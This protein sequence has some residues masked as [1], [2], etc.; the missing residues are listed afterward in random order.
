MKKETMLN[1]Q[2]SL[3][4]MKLSFIPLILMHGAWYG[5]FLIRQKPTSRVAALIKSSLSPRGGQLQLFIHEWKGCSC[6]LV[7]MLNYQVLLIPPLLPFSLFPIQENWDEH[8]GDLWNTIWSLQ[9]GQ[10]QFQLNFVGFV[11]NFC[12]D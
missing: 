5:I 7:L 1:N 9:L 3:K 10:I 12:L 11:E 8:P 6:F 2:F 4:N